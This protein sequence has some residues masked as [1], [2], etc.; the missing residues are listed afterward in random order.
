MSRAS[1]IVLML[2]GVAISAIIGNAASR[3]ARLQSRAD[4]FAGKVVLITGGSRGIGRALAHAFA[5]RG[6]NLVLAARSEDQLREVASECREIC[7]GL[8]TLIVPTDV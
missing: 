2:A 1:R 3:R 4:Y 7:P 5:G 8:Q 6:A